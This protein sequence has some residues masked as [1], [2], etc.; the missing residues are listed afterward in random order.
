MYAGPGGIIMKNTFVLNGL[1]I[2]IEGQPIA[3]DKLEVTSEM[4]AQELATS[5]GLIKALVGE[6][7]PL[8]QEAVKP[9]ATPA[10]TTTTPNNN[11]NKSNNNYNNNYKN[12]KND[13]YKKESRQHNF[14]AIPKPEGFKEVG[15]KRW[16][17]ESGSYAGED[18]LAVHV[19]NAKY[20]VIHINVMSAH[21]S[22][23]IHMYPDNTTYNGASPETIR[24]ILKHI[25][26]PEELQHYILKVVA[27]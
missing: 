22:V 21:Q 14:D 17:Y 27:L 3:I 25:G 6:L 1:N 5:G 24:E 2:T 7:K 11:Y 12:N 26:M 20:G 10:V 19:D 8:I 15:Y 4:S 13:N 9:V 23:H 18:R 16:M